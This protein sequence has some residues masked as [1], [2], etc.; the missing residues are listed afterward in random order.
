MQ[1]AF[2]ALTHP[3]VQAP[4]AGG[5]STPEL[6]AAV[7]G[8]GGLGFLA[9]GYRRP[10]QLQSDIARTRELTSA[11]FGI[12]LFV[13][14]E[15]P[16]D[17]NALESYAAALVPLARERG[18]ELGEPHFDDD[19]FEAKLALACAEEVPIVS[20][21]FGCPSAEVIGRLHERAIA[22]W[23]TVTEP[24]EAELAAARGV[25]ALIAQGVEAG[26]HRGSYTDTEGVGEIGLLALLGL[27]VATTELPL[28]ASG[29]IADGAGVGAALV[30]GARAVQIGTAFMRCPEAATDTAHRDA[31]ASPT[32][33]AI[34]R[35]FTGRRARG[36]VNT[37]MREHGGGAPAA[38]PHVHYLTAPLRAAGRREND[39]EV[40]NLWAGQAH[41]L[42]KERPAGELVRSWSTDARVALQEAER[43]LAGSLAGADDR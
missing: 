22:V 18:V 7:S 35:A 29:G 2:P 9:A 12:N 1:C 42:A 30:A 26:G 14:A 16:V 19:A 17:G 40:V 34:T 21:A 41:V 27:L 38:Y 31:L 3:I 39:P 10:E 36:L 24:A 5:P 25:D 13:L 23:A 43:R 20:F 33:T 15:R 28:I 6:A 4:M 37:F 32:P 11:P 8:A